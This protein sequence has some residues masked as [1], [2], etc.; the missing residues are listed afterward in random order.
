MSQ[1]GEGLFGGYKTGY[2]NPKASV[3]RSSGGPRVE[4]TVQDVDTY[5]FK[6]IPERGIDQKTAERFGIRTK[7][8]A[9]DGLTPEAH[10]FP[11]FLDGKRVG[12][13]KR[14]LTIPKQQKGHFSIIGFQG[15]SCDL[16]GLDGANKSSKRMIFI[17]EGEYDAAILWQCL[18]ENYKAKDGKS[19][20]PNFTVVSI[21]NGTS[22][23]VQNLAQKN[24]YKLLNKFEEIIVAFDADRAT[25]AEKAKGIMKGKDAVAAVY[26]VIPQMKVV[27]I[28]E[29]MDPC[30][31]YNKGLAV[32]LYWAA[33]KPKDYVPDGFSTYAQFRE[34]AHEI[35]VL[36]KRFPWPTLT[37]LTL[38]RRKGEGYFIG[39]GVKMG[40]SEL[41]NQLVEYITGFEKAKAAVFKFE[42]E[43]EITCKKI[44]GKRYHK[45]F[46]NA[47]K[48]MI[49]QE[50][51]TY[52][53]IWGE[54][55][56]E[57]QRGY[58]KHEELIAATDEV[59]DS[60]IYY[61]NYGRAVWDELKGAIRHA[62]IV[63][64]CEDI[65]IDPI[66]RLVQGM[67]ASEA[68][69]ELERFSDEISKLAK[70]LGFTYYCF[71]HLNKPEA[72]KPHEFGGQVQSAQFAGSRA[73]MRNTYYMWGI[74]RNKDPELPMKQRNTS[75]FVILD[76]R[77]HGRAGKFPVF[78]DID[79]GDYLEPPEGF[80][81][82]PYETLREWYAANP[83]D[84]PNSPQYVEK[85]Q[86]GAAQPLSEQNAEKGYSDIK[87]EDIPQDQDEVDPDLSAVDDV[88]PQPEP[89]IDPA[90]SALV[91]EVSDND[92]DIDDD[93]PF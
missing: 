62:V 23:A 32:Q 22:N 6:A 61:N 3:A 24:N 26:S 79:T 25:E 77:K 21:T 27:D 30:D 72:G 76:D 44:A 2:Q 87:E 57:G 9:K 20:P 35:P 17:T 16:F 55:V 73:M 56:F 19:R 74:E 88:P 70:E 71:C 11:Y 29:D 52:R 86:K 53:D 42:E 59:G 18:R 50:D 7:L 36:G 51:G 40:K 84:D 49:P 38:G 12:Y 47:E 15:V 43:N 90:I 45:D 69:Q 31:M 1:F 93:C 63:E 83:E 8:S 78:Y 14:D 10:Y 39:A 58:F 85:Q 67:S 54:Q 28:P 89:E 92:I 34:K 37:R 4:E 82:S 68:N 64:G 66:T 91:P 65:F 48:V 46:V 41:L 5:P 81:D 80:L 33:M 60:V 13:K 75:W